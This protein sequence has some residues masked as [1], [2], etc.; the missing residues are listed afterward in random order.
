MSRLFDEC[1][2]FERGALS[3]SFALVAVVASVDGRPGY[4]SLLA[5]GMWVDWNDMGRT[6]AKVAVVLWSAA[7]LCRLGPRPAFRVGEDAGCGLG[8]G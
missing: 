1:W 7:H 5:G 8:R 4:S 3:S 2:P 6:G